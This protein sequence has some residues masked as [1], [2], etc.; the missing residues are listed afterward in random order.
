ML[1][2]GRCQA[3]VEISAQLFPKLAYVHAHYSASKF[4]AT[5]RILFIF[6]R[7]IVLI[8][9][10]RPNSKDPLFGTA[11]IRIIFFTYP[12]FYN[13]WK[14]SLF[15]KSINQSTD[16]SLLLMATRLCNRVTWHSDIV[17][18]TQSWTP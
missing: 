14:H 17:L 3:S 9:R 16:H 6:G 7:I 18:T 2:F 10:I 5:I 1:L 13:V 4:N 8:I 12:L 15:S 11:I